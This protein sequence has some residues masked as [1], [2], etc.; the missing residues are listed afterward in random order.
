MSFYR[1]LKFRLRYLVCMCVSEYIYL[2][3]YVCSVLLVSVYASILGCSVQYCDAIVI[4]GAAHTSCK[5][6]LARRKQISD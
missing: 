5:M 3:V 4:K 2:C 1:L 6:L